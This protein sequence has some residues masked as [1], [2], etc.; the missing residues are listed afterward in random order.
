MGLTLT[1][2]SKKMDWYNFFIS[3]FQVINIYV[4]SS[5][6]KNEFQGLIQGNSLNLI[7]IITN[8]LKNKFST[9]DCFIFFLLLRPL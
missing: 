9:I 5:A 2:R 4:V 3:I 1:N 8:I 7:Q 6:K